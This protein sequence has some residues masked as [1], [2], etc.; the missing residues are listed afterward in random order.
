MGNLPT[1]FERSVEKMNMFNEVNGILGEVQTG[2]RNQSLTAF[3]EQVKEVRIRLGRKAYFL[4]K[5]LSFLFETVNV[6]LARDVASDGFDITGKLIG[7]CSSIIR[8]EPMKS[9]HWFYGHAKKYIESH[10][11][12]FRKD[13]HRSTCTAF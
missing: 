3:F 4:D 11:F 9:D 13:T 2:N 7:I 10:R 1:I 12:R 8:N 6:K 5:Y